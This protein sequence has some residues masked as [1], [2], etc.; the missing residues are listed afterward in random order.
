VTL[1]GLGGKSFNLAIEAVLAVQSMLCRQFPDDSLEEWRPNLFMDSPTLVI[2][3]RYFSERRRCPHGDSI[4]F[5]PDV[6]PKGILW[7]MIGEK[8]L[9][10]QENHV[11]YYQ[12]VNYPNAN[13][14]HQT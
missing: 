9:H 1:S 6:D 11:D 10:T 2:S 3:N 13:Q 5:H 8:L 14:K 12:H 7:K 4:P